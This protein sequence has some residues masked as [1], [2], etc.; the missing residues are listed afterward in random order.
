MAVLARLIYCERRFEGLVAYLRDPY[1][2]GTMRRLIGRMIVL[3]PRQEWVPTSV[4]V[5]LFLTMWM[6]T[7]YPETVFESMEDPGSQAVLHFAHLALAGL[8]ETTRNILAGLPPDTHI[9]CGRLAVYERTYTAWNA[10]D[11]ARLV[12]RVQHAMI[13]LTD[14][15]GRYVAYFQLHH[16]ELAG[17]VRRLHG[18]LGKLL[19]PA[20]VA[21]FDVELGMYEAWQL[22]LREAL[23]WEFTVHAGNEERLAL[24]HRIRA[25]IAWYTGRGEEAARLQVLRLQEELA[26][27]IGVELA[28]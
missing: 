17:Q 15:H 24:Q 10:P 8:E 11:E 26:R 1:V 20:G 25:S 22:E 13:H 5:R 27:A 19:T 21:L 28:R 2:L 7:C 3:A 18:Q 16:E 6:V 9:L 12:T 14:A 23:I 4:N